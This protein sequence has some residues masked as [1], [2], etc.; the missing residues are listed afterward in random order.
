MTKLSTNTPKSKIKNNAIDI[1]RTR[2][3]PKSKPNMT[4]PRVVIIDFERR[5]RRSLC[6]CHCIGYAINALQRKRLNVRC[7]AFRAV[8]FLGGYRIVLEHK[9]GIFF[10][11]CAAI[12]VITLF[13]KASIRCMRGRHAPKRGGLSRL[14]HLFAIEE[15]QD[16]ATATQIFRV[17]HH[18]QPITRPFQFDIEDLS[19][20]CSRTVGHHHY[21]VR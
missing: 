15:L 20:G 11:V 13:F 19:D 3:L 7:D 1:T 12:E 2:Y 8:D 6:Q 5:A 10:V 18:R 21:A 14:F 16:F 9:S 4:Y 17:R